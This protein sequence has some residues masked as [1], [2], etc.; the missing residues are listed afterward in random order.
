MSDAAPVTTEEAAVRL[1]VPP[2]LIA[3][4]K[5]HKRAVPTGYTRDRAPLYQLDEL[6][7]LAEQYHQRT[8]T[9]RSRHSEDG[10]T[11]G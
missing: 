7:P 1:D 8:A 4:W 5:Y 9:R 10:S 11:D 2:N 3:S 6:R